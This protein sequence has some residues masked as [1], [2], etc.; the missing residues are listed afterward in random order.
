MGRRKTDVL[1]FVIVIVLHTINQ[2]IKTH[3]DIEP[4]GYLLRN[5][6]NDF[7]A[8]IAILAYINLVLSSSKWDV[9]IENPLII[10]IIG[11]LCGMFWEFV[12][13]IFKK[14]S[15]SDWWD[16]LSYMVGA[17]A[18]WGITLL[19]HGRKRE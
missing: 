17:E 2:L 16:V 1:I 13:P 9:R 6:F 8:G 3:V 7:L 10:L 19:V 11:F 18:Y 5:H 14:N 4:I 12:V 15:V